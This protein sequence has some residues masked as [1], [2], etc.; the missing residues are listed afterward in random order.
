MIEYM[1]FAVLG[2][3]LLAAGVL[4]GRIDRPDKR[5]TAEPEDVAEDLTQAEEP[6]SEEEKRQRKEAQEDFKRQFDIMLTYAGAR[7][8]GDNE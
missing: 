1:L 3:A 4:I 8:E 2:A 6:E 5:K 7:T